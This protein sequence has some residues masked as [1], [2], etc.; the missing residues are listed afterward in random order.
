[1]IVNLLQQVVWIEV[2]L[3]G[4]QIGQNNNNKY[5]NKQIMN[6]VNMILILKI[7]I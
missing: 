6:L 4:K 5:N 1:M 3:Y 7:Y 2:Y